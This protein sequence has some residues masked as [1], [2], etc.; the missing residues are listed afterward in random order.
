VKGVNEQAWGAKVLQ[1]SDGKK[2]KFSSQHML[3]HEESESRGTALAVDRAR[4]E[5][6]KRASHRRFTALLVE[7][8]SSE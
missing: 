6:C 3:L 2:A 4:K 8:R 7:E 1:W 5:E